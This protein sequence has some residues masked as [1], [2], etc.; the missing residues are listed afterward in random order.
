MHLTKSFTRRSFLKA[1]VAAGCRSAASL[2]PGLSRQSQESDAF[3]LVGET[4]RKRILKAAGRYVSQTPLTITAFPAKR[5]AG[6]LHDFYSQADYF[7]PDPK[8]PNGPYIYHDGQSIL[9]ISTS[10]VS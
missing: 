10:I 8:D 5:S 2:A 4:D 3:R 1:A 9:R 7:W 6:G